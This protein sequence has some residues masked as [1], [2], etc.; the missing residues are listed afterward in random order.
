MRIR[1]LL[2][3]PCV[4]AVVS[5][6]ACAGDTTAPEA[7]ASRVAP[8]ARRTLSTLNVSISGPG[9]ITNG[10]ECTWYSSVSGGTPPY[11]YHWS[12][13]GMI[14]TGPDSASYFTGYKAVSTW[15][16]L[17]LLVT[18]ALGRQRWAPSRIIEDSYD[19]PTSC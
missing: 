14:S 8:G 7:T 5:L 9:S 18:D 15:G 1:A 12:T 16:S 19:I 17:D 13:T 6:A 3:V 2:V 10:W 11:I 4:L